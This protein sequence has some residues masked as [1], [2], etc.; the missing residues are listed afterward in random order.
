MNI[1]MNVFIKFLAYIHCRYILIVPSTF[2]KIFTR[3]RQLK[4]RLTLIILQCILSTEF[5]FLKHIL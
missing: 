1:I 4:L 2:C 3:K 5:L